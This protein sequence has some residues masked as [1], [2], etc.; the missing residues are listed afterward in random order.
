MIDRFIVGRVERISPEAPVPVVRFQSEHVRLG[1]AA[2][3]AHNLAALGARASRSWASSDTDRRRPEPPAAGTSATAGIAADGL[4]DDGTR[5]TP[6]KVRVVTERN[7]QVA[8]IDYEDDRDVDD[9]IVRRLTERAVALGIAIVLVVHARDLLIAL[10]DNPDL[11]SRRPRRIVHQP[12]V[13]HAGCRQRLTQPRGRVVVSHDS[14]ERRATAERHQVVRHI[15]G[16]AET[17]VLG[18][19][20]HDRHGRF[21]RDARH[22]ADDEAIEHDVADHEHAQAWETQHEIA[23]ASRADRRKRHA[24]E[25]PRSRASMRAAA[26]GSVTRIRNSMVESRG[27]RQHRPATN[28]AAA[29]RGRAARY[30]SF[31]MNAS[32]ITGRPR[33]ATLRNEINGID[34]PDLAWA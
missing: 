1:G 9:A 12:V 10:G 24:R 33:S 19:K 7:Q 31:K 34:R 15:R 27:R 22:T 28:T 21:G 30:Q 23:R 18:L 3:V 4:V 25:S 11:F 14:H 8:R 5:P 13:G 26:K 29:T 16:A 6:E 20:P 2:N 17:A 32:Q